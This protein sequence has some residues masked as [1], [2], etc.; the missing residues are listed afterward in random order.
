MIPSGTHSSPRPA[1]ES[2]PA[3]RL[4]FKPLP[5]RLVAAATLG[6]LAALAWVAWALLAFAASQ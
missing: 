2:L 6:S 4:E 1:G 5:L 3:R